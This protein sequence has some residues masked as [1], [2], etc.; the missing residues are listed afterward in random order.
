VRAKLTALPGD[1]PD[2]PSGCQTAAQPISMCAYDRQLL[3]LT[4]PLYLR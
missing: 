2:I 4:S 1:T 3:A